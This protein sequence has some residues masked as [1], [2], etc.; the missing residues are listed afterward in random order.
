MGNDTLILSGLLREL[1]N[2]YNN[3]KKCE[4]I[5]IQHAVIAGASAF[6]P[7][8]TASI[9]VTLISIYSMLVR[10]FAILEIKLADNIIRTLISYCTTCLIG[11]L[12]AVVIALLAPIVADLLKIIPGF[13]LIAGYTVGPISNA[14]IVYVYGLIFL[15][16]LLE[17]CKS[18]KE[19]TEDNLKENIKSKARDT[20]NVKRSM[21]E[22]KEK[23]KNTDFSKHKKDAEDIF[24]KNKDKCIHCGAELHGNKDKCPD[25]GE[26]PLV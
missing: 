8:P 20:S 14:V 4:Q 10:L 11:N 5:I 2:Y 18:G 15:K 6:V 16:A 3:A 7:F 21:K 22:A 25:C 13:G 17:L 24:E 9:I 12:S 1:G 23:F 26:K 19:L